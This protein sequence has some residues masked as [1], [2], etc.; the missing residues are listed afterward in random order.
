MIA[1][2]SVAVGMLLL[3]SALPV[4]AQM[5]LEAS[6]TWKDYGNTRVHGVFVGDVGGTGAPEVVTAGETV[7]G[8]ADGTAGLEVASGGQAYDGTHD[9]GELR[10]WHL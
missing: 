10:V 5:T 3:L 8:E 6:T 9:R 2:V 1:V 7:D 4:R